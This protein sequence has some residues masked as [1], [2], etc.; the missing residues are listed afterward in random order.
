[1]NR[2]EVRNLLT[3]LRSSPTLESKAISTLSTLYH[4]GVDKNLIVSVSDHSDPLMSRLLFKF[5][6][7]YQLSIIRGRFSYGDRESLFE[8]APQDSAGDFVSHLF[9]DGDDF[10]QG[11]SPV[12]GY[13]TK[14]RVKFYMNRVATFSPD[15]DD[16]KLLEST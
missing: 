16:T 6:N 14:E 13:C 12:L 8:I 5:V 15:T 11:E 9:Y 10:D 7:G 3:Q 2:K 1:M 4:F